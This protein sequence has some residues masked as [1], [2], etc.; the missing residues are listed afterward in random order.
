MAIGSI[1]GPGITHQP[2]MVAGGIFYRLPVID[3]ATVT[4]REQVYVQGDHDIACRVSPNGLVVDM[5]GDGTAN[6]AKPRTCR[7]FVRMATTSTGKV[8]RLFR[9]WWDGIVWQ[10]RELVAFRSQP[11]GENFFQDRWHALPATH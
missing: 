11:P 9:L 8:I 3:P 6:G 1:W 2:T 5:P 10:T 7:Y 4:L